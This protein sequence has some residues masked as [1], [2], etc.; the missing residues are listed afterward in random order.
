MNDTVKLLL[1]AYESAYR[2]VREV[3]REL[4]QAV[5]LARGEDAT[6]RLRTNHVVEELIVINQEIQSIGKNLEEVKSNA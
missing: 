6:G 5:T 3:I 4:D 2:G 1:G